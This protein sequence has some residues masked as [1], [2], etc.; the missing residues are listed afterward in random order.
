MKLNAN[1]LEMCVYILPFVIFL[2]QMFGRMT[3]PMD[4]SGAID[5]DG[6][7]VVLYAWQ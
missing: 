4:E 5:V 1:N 6:K 7:Q 2:S 3:A